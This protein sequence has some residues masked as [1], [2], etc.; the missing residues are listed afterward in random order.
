VGNAAAQ[1]LQLDIYGELIDSVYL[2]NKYAEPISYDFWV[3]LRRMLD[4][5]S[6]N[7]GLA[8]EGIWE[9]RG[10]RR[11]FVNS[12]MQCWV[13][14]DRGLRIAL[15]RGLPVDFERLRA[16]RDNIY[17]PI[18][19]EGWSPRRKAFTQAFGSDTL[20][21]ANLIMPLTMFVPAADP[22]MVQTVDAI[23]QDLVSGSLVHRYRIDDEHADGLLGREGTF[24]MC[25]FWLVLR[26]DRTLRRGARELPAGLQASFADERRLYV[27]PPAGV[28]KRNGDSPERR[29][30]A[31]V[32]Y[33]CTAY[34]RGSRRR[35]PP[36][37]P[38]P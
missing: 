13:A 24:S 22:R 4:W 20:D 27:G 33:L 30:A 16:A 31:Q 15:K 32:C 18:M 23:M 36:P 34:Q 19:R 29:I 14:L 10:G 17:E 25:S 6:R 26:R 7:W 2:Y 28:K 35:P 8:D 9:V 11:H 21:A 1:Q 5:V 37:P 38:P 12:K 3:Q